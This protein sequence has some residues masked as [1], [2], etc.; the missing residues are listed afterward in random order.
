MNVEDGIS[1]YADGGDRIDVLPEEMAGIV[2]AAYGVSRDRAKAE[3]GLRVIHHKPGMHFDGDSYAVVPGEFCV[4]DPIGSHNF[5]PLPLE[6][7][8]IVRWPG[9][10]N[11]VGGS[12][13]V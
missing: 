12:G 8:A 13:I 9:A 6:N 1:E 10:G 3:H 5:I 2:V 11:P 7:P 4:L